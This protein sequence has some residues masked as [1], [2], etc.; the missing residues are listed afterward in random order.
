MRGIHR[1]HARTAELLHLYEDF[2]YR[3]Q[4]RALKPRIPP[5]EHDFLIQAAQRIPA[6]HT[7]SLSSITKFLRCI[8]SQTPAPVAG[9][10]HWHRSLLTKKRTCFSGRQPDSARIQRASSHCLKDAPGPGRL[11]AEPRAQQLHRSGVHI[12][13][14][15]SQTCRVM[16]LPSG[17]AQP[18]SSTAGSGQQ[19]I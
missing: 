13:R 7:K 18:Y 2:S 5:G 10:R 9:E 6:G 1:L 17:A 12:T 3:Q 19:A 8:G 14:R 11:L 4:H 16:R 15:S